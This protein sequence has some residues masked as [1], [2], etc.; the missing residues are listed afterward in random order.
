MQNIG[1]TVL[2]IIKFYFRS[3]GDFLLKSE[4]DKPPW[5]QVSVLQ[6]FSSEMERVRIFWPTS[7]VFV[8]LCVCPSFNNSTPGLH[9]PCFAK[10]N[11]L[12][13]FH[14][15]CSLVAVQLVLW[16]CTK[17]LQIVSESVFADCL[18]NNLW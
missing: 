13:K 7:S 4:M 16:L 15:G 11:T 17:L 8:I 1:L 6:Q 18:G 2:R 5:K 10:T 12:T 9:G 3:F 14:Q